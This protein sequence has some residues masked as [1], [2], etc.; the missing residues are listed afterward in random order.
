[1]KVAVSARGSDLDSPVDGRFG[2][3]ERFLVVDTETGSVEAVDNAQNLAAA[4]GAGVQAARTLIEHGVEAV[5]TGNVGPNAF[6]TLQAAGVKVYAGAAGTVAE[7]VER[8]KAAGLTPVS[9]PT[10]EHGHGSV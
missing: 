2:R 1:M 7:A 6:R 10:V 4:H 9:D 3:A 8:F 5:L